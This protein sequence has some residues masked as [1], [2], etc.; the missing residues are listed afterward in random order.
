M[1]LLNFSPF[2]EDLL[3][4]EK[5]TTTIRLGTKYGDLK[6]NDKI[7]IGVGW[8]ANESKIIKKGIISK[9]VIKKIRELTENDLVGES[10]DCQNIDAVKY[11]LSSIYHKIVTESDYVTLIKWTYL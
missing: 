11:V 1:K 2:Y 4:A 7:M 10:P 6:E 3:L 5:K 8:H 9:I